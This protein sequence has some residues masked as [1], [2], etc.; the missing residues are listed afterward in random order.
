[1]QKQY[2][3]RTTLHAWGVL[4]RALQVSQPGYSALMWRHEHELQGTCCKEFCS[5]EGLHYHF[6][7]STRNPLER[8]Q[9][10][11][12]LGNLSRSCLRTSNN[13]LWFTS[14]EIPWEF[15]AQAVLRSLIGGLHHARKCQF[16]GIVWEEKVW[17]VFA[18]WTFAPE[19]FGKRW[20][21]KR[22]PVLSLVPGSLE[23]LASRNPCVLC[24]KHGGTCMTY[25]LRVP[26]VWENGTRNQIPVQQGGGRKEM[27]K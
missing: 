3:E 12:A 1:M 8:D 20:K 2:E 10:Q 19:T 5:K 25:Y 22:K 21:R 27:C 11:R 9:V 13:Q 7:W 17:F 23:C 4:Q 15:L 6:E 18:Q 24:Q 16:E 26:K 14:L